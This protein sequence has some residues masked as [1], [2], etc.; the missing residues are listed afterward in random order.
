[1]DFEELDP[2]RAAAGDADLYCS[3]HPEVLWTSATAWW[4]RGG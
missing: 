4:A 3:P 2:G 1:L